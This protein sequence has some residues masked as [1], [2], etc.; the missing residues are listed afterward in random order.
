MRIEYMP[1]QKTNELI[2]IKE[3]SPTI[4]PSGQKKRRA[5]FQCKCGNEF[6]AIID[7]VRRNKIK[8]CECTKIERM[9]KLR[10]THGLTKTDIHS[11][12]TNM[13]TRCYNPKTWNYSNYGGR[14][15]TICEEWRNDFKA[16]YN[17]AIANGFQKGL[18][19]DRIDNDGNYEPANCRF[20]TPKENCQ[21]RIRK[22]I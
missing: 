5:L 4:T 19:I 1:N 17:W 2:F 8:S 16:F 21:N 11:V 10:L 7:N 9:K 20:V 13:K 3:I 15:I 12:W 6:E 22:A 14:G 18:Q